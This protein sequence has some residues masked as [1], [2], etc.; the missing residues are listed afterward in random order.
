MEHRNGSRIYVKLNISIMA[1][2]QN[3]GC[4]TT[5][6]L[7]MGG[8]GVRGKVPGLETHSL[9][10]VLIE[11]LDGLEPIVVKLR[12]FVVYQ[13][14]GATGLMWVTRETNLPQLM[15]SIGS[16]AA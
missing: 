16:L 9:V 6:D 10:T 15:T 12:A 3:L 8:L 7:S 1:G 14:D 2:S 11:P 4:Y 5:T 13:Q